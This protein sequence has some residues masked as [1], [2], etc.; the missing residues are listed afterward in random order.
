MQTLRD[1]L[2]AVY[3]GSPMLVRAA[4][5]NLVFL[6]FVLGG[7]VVDDR[8]VTGAP[9]WLKPV[10]FASSVTIST[11]SIAWMVHA[12]PPTA[13]VRRASTMIAV[14]LTLE[15]M[16]IIL[17]AAR[18]TT[19]HFNADTAFDSAVFSVMGL[20]ILIVWICSMF[21]LWRHCRTPV[22]DRTLAMAF[23]IG[24][25]LNIIGAGVGWRMT[26][27]FPGQIEAIEQGVRPR[28]VGA[29][30]VGAPDG[31]AGMPITKWSLTNGDLR[32]PHFVGMHA[33]Q[34]L[35]LLVVALRTRR[36]ARQD[37]VERVTLY[38]ASAASALLFVGVLVQALRGLP[39]FSLL[40]S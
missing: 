2:S 20:G 13:G 4:L 38:A 32:V 14:L 23:R 27:P 17:Q 19:S 7:L 24:L 5:I 16:L 37:R 15:V 8:I 11:L 40:G 29:H 28:I 39:L 30:T 34:L 18:G 10:K 21:I 33:L 3:A 26:Q 12:L 22:A 31:G 36:R 9:V 1:N 35:P 25:A 6:A